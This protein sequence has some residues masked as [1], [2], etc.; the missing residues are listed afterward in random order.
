MPEELQEIDIKDLEAMEYFL[1]LKNQYEIQR[2]PWESRWKQALAA[3]HLTDELDTVYNGRANIQIPVMKWKVNGIAARINKTIFNVQPIGRLEDKYIDSVEKNIID[4]WNKYIFENQ[5]DQINF[6]EAYKSFI[7]NKTIQ[8]TAV[9]K[10]TQ[11]FEEKEFSFFDEGEKEI[12][13][14]K[15][16]TYFRNMLLTEFYSDVNKEDINDSQANIHTTVVTMESLLENEQRVEVQEFET[17]FG[18]EEERINVGVY[19]N[20]SLIQTNG[21][22]IT[23]EQAAYIELLGLN[24]GEATAFQKSLKESRRTGFVQIDECYGKFDLDGDGISEEVICTIA[25]GR[26]VIRIE[27]TPFKHKR[28]VRPFI[29]GTYEKI[30]NCLYGNSN[31][32]SGLNLLMELNASRAQA[33]DAKTRS[34]SP[35]WYMDDTKNVTWDN[36]WRPNGIIKGQG[37]NGITPIINPNLSSVSIMDSELISRDLDQLWSLSPVQQGTS[38]RSLIPS[39]A[40]GTLAVIS[41]N[42]MPLNDIIDNSIENEIKPFIEMLFERDIVFKTTQDLLEVWDPKELEAFGNI[43]EQEMDSL[44]FSFSIKILGNLELSNEVAHQQGWM[45]FIQWAMTVPP[46]AKRLDWTAV[47]D[48][49]LRSFGIKDDADGIWLDKELLAESDAAQQQSQ[50][51]QF[52]LQ[53]QQRQS[54][55]KES[56]EDRQFEIELDTEADIVKMQSEA[57][58]EKTT[59]QKIQ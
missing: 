40:R 8:G 23:D 53:E 14:V 20:L 12:I 3:Y 57:F 37:Q 31:V 56:R 46:V 22:S 58:I 52:M 30:S 36:T 25:N 51:Q 35:M 7:K 27:P 15:D 1:S 28:Y 4:L 2:Q 16:N 45:N 29:V 34:V 50:Q 11:E 48:K 6:K 59:G 32:I 38:D 17:E 39:T 10:I 43:E 54:S 18:I 13:S 55:R 21:N 42:D 24:K 49:Q 19:K 44:L 26:V 5:L 9:A 47:A 33:T 41:Q